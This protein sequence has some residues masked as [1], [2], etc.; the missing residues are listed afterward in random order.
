VA[1]ARAKAPWWAHILAAVAVAFG[2][3]SINASGGILLAPGGAHAAPGSRGWAW[4][5]ILN[6]LAYVVSGIGLWSLR[7]WAVRGAV[8]IAATTLATFAAYGL[9]VLFGN[10]FDPR[11]V[12]QLGVRFTVW[13]A[14]AA[15]AHAWLTRNVQPPA[16]GDRG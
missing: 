4:F 10:P 1:E 6:G 12:A 13:T 8:V 5:G 14:I 11:T 3:F 15:S 2:A 7:L 16:S 9:W